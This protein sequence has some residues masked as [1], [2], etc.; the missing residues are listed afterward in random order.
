VKASE[1]PGRHREVGSEG[2]VEQW[3]ELTNRNWIRGAKV[4]R[5]RVRV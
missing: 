4:G 5:R 1:A 2:R 3:C